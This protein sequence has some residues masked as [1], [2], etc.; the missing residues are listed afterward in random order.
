MNKPP[1]LLDS[2]VNRN[3]WH[4][5]P[6]QSISKLNYIQQMDCITTCGEDKYVRI[7]S[8]H[9]FLHCNIN[10]VKFSYPNKLWNLPYDWMSIIIGELED[11]INVVTHLDQK[12][13]PKH[14]GF[15]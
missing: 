10:I 1:I 6:Y 11:A 15:A 13:R 2:V 5:H 9:G 3:S 7:W 8:R 14:Q 12:T 4:A